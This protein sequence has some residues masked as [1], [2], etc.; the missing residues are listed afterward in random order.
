MH[1]LTSAPGVRLTMRNPVTLVVDGYDGARRP[2]RTRHLGPP[3][4]NTVIADFQHVLDREGNRTE[5]LRH[6]ANRADTYSYDSLYRATQF[7]RDGTIS[8]PVPGAATNYTLDGNGNWDNFATDNNMNEYSVLQGN[9]RTYD[10]NGNLLMTGTMPTEF[11]YQFDPWNR[12]V[13]ASTGGGGIPVS[14]ATYDALGRRNTKT[15][16]NSG[17]YNDTTAFSYDGGA[18][19][20][21]DAAVAG[22]R[23]FVG[24]CQL[25]EDGAARH[26]LPCGGAVSVS[27]LRMDATTVAGPMPPL[28]LHEDGKGNVAALTDLAQAPV[29]RYDYDA[30]GVPTFKTGAGV[31]TGGSAS[32]NGNPWLFGDMHWEPESGLFEGKY[33]VTLSKHGISGGFATSFLYRPSE[34]RCA[35]RTACANS[36]DQT[37]TAK[38]FKVEI[39]G[40]GAYT[41]AAGNPASGGKRGKNWSG[42]NFAPV[43]EPGVDLALRVNPVTRE[44]IGNKIDFSTP[45][46]T[47][48]AWVDH[49]DFA[50]PDP[51]LLGNKLFVGGLSWD[52]SAIKPGIVV[53]G[54]KVKESWSVKVK[55]PWLRT[56]G[57]SSAPADK[58]KQSLYFPESMLNETR[59]EMGHW[60][61]MSYGGR[62]VRK[63]ITVTIKDRSHSGATEHEVGHWLGMYS[64]GAGG[65]M[66]WDNVRNKK[67]GS[68]DTGGT[69]A[70]GP[71]RIFIVL[72]S[73]GP[74][75]MPVGIGGTNFGPNS[76]PYIN[77]AP[78][79][80]IFNAS[81]Q[82]IPLLGSISVGVRDAPLAPPRPTHP[83][84]PSLPLL[85]LV[86]DSNGASDIY[87]RG[88]LR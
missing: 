47:S 64:S 1:P 7:T 65:G 66:S 16:T 32:A 41:F 36:G 69:G 54:S 79:I 70:S 84:Q 6:H 33:Y 59:H 50:S 20:T 87:R 45:G 53:V 11:N 52:T 5:E 46:D 81:I 63:D 2:V 10:N 56:D 30:Y 49:P 61:G 62:S 78:S 80:S 55:F 40:A 37:L 19:L 86:D 48:G 74:S 22:L 12:L 34:G 15:V 77:S 8:P 44:E 88:P 23:E 27:A 13:S 51:E 68:G 58:R 25:R 43:L 14:T 26:E 28:F 57:G 31:P 60:V 9:S 82:N 38:G 3:P 73:S 24:A 29:E 85:P 75:F 39:A 76:I 21:E 71:P 18:L 4:M 42:T 17:P 83:W 72:P 67:W 35:S